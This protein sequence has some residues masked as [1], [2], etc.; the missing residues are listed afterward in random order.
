MT[1]I[2]W[3]ARG[4]GGGGLLRGAGPELAQC[5]LVGGFLVVGGWRHRRLQRSQYFIIVG[6]RLRKGCTVAAMVVAMVAVLV[7]VLVFAVMG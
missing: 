7:L 6:S 2:A 1:R 5:G 3:L 4:Y